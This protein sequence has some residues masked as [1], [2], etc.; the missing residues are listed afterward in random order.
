MTE[1]V[2]TETMAVP[3]PEPERPP[4]AGPRD[5]VRHNLF[6]SPLDVAVTIVSGLVVGYVLYRLIGFVFVTGRWDIVRVNLKLFMVGRYPDDELWRIAVVLAGLALYGGLVAGFLAHRRVLTGT[7]DPAELHVPWWRRG[8]ALFVRL[9]PLV[10]GALLLLLLSTS[11]GPWLTAGAVVVAAVVGRLLGLLLPRRSA[12]PLIVIGIAGFAAA[13]WFLTRVAGWDDW[14]GIMLNLFLALAG[15]TLCFPLGILLAL[16]RAAGRDAGSRFN[17]VLA[18]VVLGAVP[19]VVHVVTGGG[20][21][22]SWGTVI[23]LV[24]AAAL[25]YGGWRLGRRSSLPLLRALSVGYI[26]ALRGV[27]L[28]VLLLLSYLAL[29]FFLPTWYDNPPGLVVRAI[30]ALT[31]FT[32]AYVA[33]IVRGGLQSLPKGQTEAAQ[34]LGLSPV[35]TMALIVLPQALRNV[36][37]ALVGQFISLFKDTTLAAAAM[38]FLDVFNVARAVP[39][40]PA[41]QGQALTAETLAFVMFLFWVGCITMSRESQRLERKLGVGTR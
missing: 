11:A 41:F 1:T 26:E 32:A 18:A 3:P 31:L 13:V 2:L 17:A 16:G 40:Q 27:P 14:G 10:L 5:W 29:G 25:A 33:E 8:L 36:I 15:I 22:L 23:V 24:L 35:K 30:V 12:V 9:W 7:A 38:G 34:A 4:T 28:F 39:S 19:I 6:R 20:F 21:E 37:P